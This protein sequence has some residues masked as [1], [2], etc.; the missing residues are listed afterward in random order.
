MGFY[1]DPKI[2]QSKKNI[3]M[4]SYTSGRIHERSKYRD[5]VLEE[6]EYDLK[7]YRKQG[8]LKQT[9]VVPIQKISTLKKRSTDNG[10]KINKLLEKH[11][12]P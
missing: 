9:V 3:I 7:L 12:L 8:S 2:N 4:G 5:L 10:N 1:V 6:R 11:S